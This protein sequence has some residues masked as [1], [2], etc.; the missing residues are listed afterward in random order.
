MTRRRRKA[1]AIVQSVLATL[2]LP[3]DPRD[4]WHRAVGM[5][6]D[7]LEAEQGLARKLEEDQQ[8]PAGVLV[9]IGWTVPEF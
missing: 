5:V 1:L 4:N 9:P 6:E 8:H 3:D 2:S 7:A